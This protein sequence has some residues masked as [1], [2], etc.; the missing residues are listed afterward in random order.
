MSE[1]KDIDISRKALGLEDS[2]EDR[3]VI[4]NN[5]VEKK[6]NKAQKVAETFLGGDVKDVMTCIVCDVIIP[7]G[8]DLLH[9]IVTK[10]M[11]RLIYGN[12]APTRGARPSRR[13]FTSYG[14]YYSNRQSSQRGFRELTQRERDTHEF[15]NFIAPSR[16]QADEVLTYLTELIERKGQA[17]VGDFLHA[18]GK[19]SQ[20]T[21]TDEKWGWRSMARAQIRQIREGW[22][23]ELPPTEEV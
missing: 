21:F 12:D 4:G 10:G 14:Q 1:N 9:D 20:A 7:T 15:S 5:F 19:G 23:M 11:D 8:K 16:D 6:K 17:T 13:E 2:T 18:I 3:K 22:L